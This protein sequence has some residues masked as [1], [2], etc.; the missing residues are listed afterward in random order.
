MREH[1]NKKS[2]NFDDD[3]VT[4][5]EKSSHPEEELSENDDKISIA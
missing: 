1:S 5:F 2:K 4:G 3:I